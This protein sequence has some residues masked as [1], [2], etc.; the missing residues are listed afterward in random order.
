MAGG[1]QLTEDDVL[2]GVKFSDG[3]GACAWPIEVV[4][5]NP[6]LGRVVKNLYKPQDWYLIPYQ[7]LVPK[8]VEN[9]LMAGRFISTTHRALASARVMGPAVVMGQAIGVA[10][11]LSIGSNITPRQLDVTLLQNELKSQGVW[12]GP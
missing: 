8:G 12:L 4:N 9:L 10:A 2:N 6:L 1:Y 5:A 3:I 7:C 11:T